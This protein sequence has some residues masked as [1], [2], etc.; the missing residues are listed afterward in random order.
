MKH[1]TII[2][3]VLFLTS[4]SLTAQIN[5]DR[6]DQ[7]ESSSTV[8]KGALQVETGFQLNYT[9]VDEVSIKTTATPNNLFRYGITKGFEL[10][11]VSQYESFSVFDF[12]ESGISDLEIGFKAQLFKKE[13]SNTEVA[14][15]S[16]LIVPSGSTQFTLDNYGTI[17][18]FLISH[19]LSEDINLG[20]NIGYDYLGTGNGNLTYTLA[21]G[22]AI[23][24]KWGMYAEPYGE[25]FDM[26]EFILNFDA[27]I[28]YLLNNNIQFDFSFGTGITDRMNYVAL[29]VSWLME[30][31]KN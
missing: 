6:P 18:R 12:T 8:P 21:L 3:V 29:G 7:T 14:F 13:N 20:Y 23:N 4:C 11:M 31:Q 16:H 2:I 25:L 22:K 17:N 5:T 24:D 26:E 19:Q 9:A 1:N 27:G 15:L 10:R 28:T 30:S